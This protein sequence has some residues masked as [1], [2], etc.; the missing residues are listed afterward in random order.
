LSNSKRQTA[1]GA[2]DK[3][4]RGGKPR[5]KKEGLRVVYVCLPV[6]RLP[7]NKKKRLIHRRGPNG[8]PWRTAER[9]CK[10]GLL[11]LLKRNREVGK[12]GTCGRN[13]KT[14]T[15]NSLGWDGFRISKRSTHPAEAEWIGVQQAQEW[16]N[17]HCL[18]AKC[19]PVKAEKREETLEEKLAKEK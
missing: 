13:K 6:E 17:L 14:L 19:T 12:G 4:G 18:M 16:T 10:M 15:G 1:D 5:P 2:L 9:K 7:G 3:A 8:P 11:V